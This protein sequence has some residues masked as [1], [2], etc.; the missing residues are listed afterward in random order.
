M[1]CFLSWKPPLPPHLSRKKIPARPHQ[2]LHT[3]TYM[4]VTWMQRKADDD[5]LLFFP[6]PA[7]RRTKQ[8]LSGRGCLSAAA[9]GCK[10]TRS[11]PCV[12]AR[13]LMQVS[14]TRSLSLS[15]AHSFTPFI[16]LPSGYI[17]VPTSAFPTRQST[18]KAHD[19]ILSWPF[20][21]IH[22]AKWPGPSPYHL[23]FFSIRRIDVLD[24]GMIS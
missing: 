2:L 5:S 15:L 9:S 10:S 17:R 19:R 11:A 13:L 20:V 18:P 21:T 22:A 8:N 4:K 6:C 14:L 16:H 3:V 23:S 1:Q 24:A 12:P 7:R